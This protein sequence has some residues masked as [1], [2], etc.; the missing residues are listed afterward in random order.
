MTPG[1]Q[2]LHASDLPEDQTELL[3]I[4]VL[5]LSQMQ[6]TLVQPFY[7]ERGTTPF[8][9]RAVT[10]VTADTPVQGPDFPIPY[11]YRC[12]IR[13]RRHAGSPVGY[14]AAS[15]QETKLSDYRLEL[16]N[17][18]SVDFPSIRNAAEIWFS[19]DTNTIR[20]EVIAET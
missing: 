7:G 8:M 14:V 6:E 1:A 9:V 15:S 19:A 12:T 10:V 5:I 4:V 11:G 3:R 18:D 13:M 2:A 16:G 20:F 17:G